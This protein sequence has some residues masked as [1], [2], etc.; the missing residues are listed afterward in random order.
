M[1]LVT[2]LRMYNATPAAAGAWQSLFVHVFADAGADVRFIE[3]RD[4]LPIAS[5]WRKPG[6]CGAFMCGLP[7]ARAERAMQA[8]A[9]PVPAPARYAGLP[10]YCSEFLVR[11]DTGFASLA[12]TFGQRIGWMPRD[13]QSGFNAP[14]ALLARYTDESRRSLYRES[15]GPFTTPAQLLDAIRGE[16]VDVVA[17]DSFYL[18]LVRLHAPSR[19]AGLRTIA[20]TPWT[21]ISLLVAA[22]D[23]ERGL[24]ARL[25]QILLTLHLQPSASQQLRDVALTRFA[26]PDIASYAQL[27][28]M[29]RYA[30]SR[31]YDA[32]R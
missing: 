6:L 2:S 26:E 16:E 30:E 4:P 5:L 24:I 15:L 1:A 31:G 7:F 13:S 12:D 3:H 19:L 28:E 32:I 18:D 21:P 20:T 29:A 17:I 23:V 9:A 22:P 8:I 11:D 10:R 25:R 27:L 14:R